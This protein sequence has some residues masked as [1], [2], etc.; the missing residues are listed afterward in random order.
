MGMF[1]KAA[2]EVLKAVDKPLT[3]LEITKVAR[4]R[5]LLVYRFS[6]TYAY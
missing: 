3:A 6:K 4:E 5:G 2:Y 1:L